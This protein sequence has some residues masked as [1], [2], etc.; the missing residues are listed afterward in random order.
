MKKHRSRP[1]PTRKTPPKSINTS[2]L[3]QKVWN[4]CH[5]LRDTKIPKADDWASLRSKTGEPLEAHYLATLPDCV[6]SVS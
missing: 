6:R 4:F 2:A 5:T 3:I 1:S